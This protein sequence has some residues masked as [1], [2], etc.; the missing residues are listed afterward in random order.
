M[1]SICDIL[2]RLFAETND[3]YEIVDPNKI[4]TMRDRGSV[5]FL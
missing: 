1:V 5:L 3:V 4:K 2:I